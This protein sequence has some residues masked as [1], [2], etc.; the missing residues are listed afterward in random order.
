[1]TVRKKSQKNFE[2]QNEKNGGK[3]VIKREKQSFDICRLK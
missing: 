1:M 2:I 3:W